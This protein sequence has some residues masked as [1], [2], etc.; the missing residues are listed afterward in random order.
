MLPFSSA[1][2]TPQ[3]FTVPAENPD[4]TLADIAKTVDGLEAGGNTAMYEAL[5]EAIRLVNARR[6]ANPDSYPTVVLL[7][8]GEANGRVSLKQFQD[9]YAA[10]PAA[11]RVPVFTIR[12]G[13][14]RAADLEAVASATGGRAFDGTK[15]LTEAFR[16][17]RGY[18]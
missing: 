11:E 18:Q 15:D 12:F 5:Q 14:A 13:D 17:I 6:A 2:G 9:A 3:Q 10:L 1:P 8:D 16:T 4:A 7:T